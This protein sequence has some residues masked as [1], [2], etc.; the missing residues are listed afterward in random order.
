MLF[1]LPRNPQIHTCTLVCSHRG[2][3]PAHQTVALEPIT[4][5]ITVSIANKSGGL[6]TIGGASPKVGKFKFSLIEGFVGV[7]YQI[8]LLK[9]IP[10]GDMSFDDSLLTF[11]FHVDV[12]DGIGFEITNKTDATA[13]INWSSVSYIDTAGEAHKVVH[14]GVRFSEKNVPLVPT[15]IPPNARITESVFPVDRVYTIPTLPIAGGTKRHCCL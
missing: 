14:A 3:F 13:S 2:G 9:P 10:N 8:A 6:R 5:F 4:S 12:S 1:A 15:V 7:R 11:H